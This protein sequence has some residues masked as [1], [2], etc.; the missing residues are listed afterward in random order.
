M[1]VWR[2]WERAIAYKTKPAT[3]PATARMLIEFP[4]IKCDAP[5]AAAADELAGAAELP[6]AVAEGAALTDSAAS[7]APAVP[8]TML[9]EGFWP[10]GEVALVAIAA[11]YFFFQKWEQFP[12]R[13]TN[14]TNLEGSETLLRCRWSVKFEVIVSPQVWLT[15]GVDCKYHAWL[16]V[17]SRRKDLRAEKPQ[18]CFE[19]ISLT[20]WRNTKVYILPVAFSTRGG[21]ASFSYVHVF[22]GDIYITCQSPA[23]DWLGCA[24][25][26]HEYKLHTDQ[27]GKVGPF[28]SETF[29]NPEL[30]PAAVQGAAN[31]DWT[32]DYQAS[33]SE[34]I[35][36]CSGVLTWFLEALAVA[37]TF[38]IVSRRERCK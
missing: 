27:V 34:K 37:G 8:E 20:V 3:R 29:W 7:V 15:G 9:P 1:Q 26:L 16:T 23:K 21:K 2:S 31:V 28:G 24:F 11:C 35:H 14:G 33:L 13:R 32:T 17:C 5:L 10:V 18:R 4:D 36:L 30:T 22:Q 25:E 6:A 19:E 12:V 38:N